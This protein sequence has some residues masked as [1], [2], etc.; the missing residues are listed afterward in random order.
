MCCFN[1]IAGNFCDDGVLRVLK[2]PLRSLDLAINQN[3]S[4]HGMEELSW[5]VSG[6]L[7]HLGL[8][9]CIGL[10]AYKGTLL[11]RL[12]ELFPSLVSL[13]LW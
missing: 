11:N 7:R 1:T 10:M 4:V 2:C 5:S 9:H 8:A 13:D 3:I 6:S 12:S